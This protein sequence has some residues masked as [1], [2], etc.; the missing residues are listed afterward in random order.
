M[1]ACIHQWLVY[2]SINSNWISRCKFKCVDYQISTRKKPVLS[3]M[4]LGRTPLQ[5]K[6][7]SATQMKNRLMFINLNFKVHEPGIKSAQSSFEAPA[8][9]CAA[10]ASLTLRGKG[11]LSMKIWQSQHISIKKLRSVG[12]RSPQSWSPYTS[13]NM[14][15]LGTGSH[16]GG[17]NLSIGTCLLFK[18]CSHRCH[19][20]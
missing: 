13:S 12:L 9:T 6:K 11:K 1:M 8:S 2:K 10:C 17:W 4:F 19:I 18:D 3:P 14:Q 20:N 15:G 7:Q 5:G 16:Y